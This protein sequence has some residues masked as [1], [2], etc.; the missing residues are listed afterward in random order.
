MAELVQSVQDML[1]EETWTRATIS[2][3]TQNNLKEFANIVEKAHSENCAD[4]IYDICQEHLSHSKDSIIA[5]YICGVLDL[6][7]GSLD[8]SSLVTLVDI[9]KNNH[10]E[11]I[12]TYLC[13]SILE[14]DPNNKFALRTLAEGYRA[15]G[16]EKYWDLYAHIVK[17]DFEEADLARLLAEHYE[18]AGDVDLTISYYKKAILR[19]I[20]NS[21]YNAIKEVWSKLIQYIPQEIDFFQLLRRKISKQMGDIRTTTLMQ[22]LYN[23]Y[24]DNAPSKK[25][26]WDVAITILKQNLEVEPKDIWARKEIADCF[27]GKYKEHSHLEEYIRTSN[28]T[29]SYRNVFEAIND[30][31]KHIAFDKGSYVFHRNWGVGRIRKLEG[32]TLT[33]N[34]GRIVGIKEMKLSMA[35]TALKP[36]AKDHIWVL[37]ATMQK[38]DL[39][40]SVKADKAETLKII[41]RSFDNNC[42]FK[43]IKAELVPSILTPGEWTSWNSAAKKI[44]ETDSNFGVNPNDISMYT[45]RDGNI[46]PEE[47]ISNEFKAQK[48]FFARADLLVKFF[49]S[50]DT[51]NSSE[52]FAEMYSYFTGYLKNISKVNEQVLASY[53]LVRS[54]SAIDKQF[55]FPVKETFAEIYNRIEDPKEIYLLLKDSKSTHFKDDFIRCIKLLPNWNEEYVKLFPIVLKEELLN[56]LIKEGH[57]E[58]VQKLVR[59]S[60]EAFKD[61]R[62]T[63]LF[64]FKECQDKDWFN[65]AGVS[66]E[67]QLIT[68]INIIELTFREIN[69]HVNSTENKKINKNAT[70]LLF[71]TDAIFNYMFANGED[72]VKKMYTLIDDIA[73]IDPSYKALARNKILEKYPDFKFRVSE[74]K[75]QQSVGLIVTAKK[76]AEKKAEVDEIQNVL[77]PKNAAEVADAKAKGD[78][79][80]NQE[81]KSAKEE[82]HFLNLKLTNLQN[83]LNRAVVFDPTTS[84]TAI[85]SFGTVATLK[86][87]QTGNEETYTILGPWESDPDNNVISYMA[88]FGDAILNKKVG[89]VLQFTINEHKY[90]YTVKN[91]SKA[92][93]I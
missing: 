63:V 46:S 40:K 39:I 76:L 70:D 20:N 22:E 27:R 89:D 75:K 77:I 3:Y 69:N 56:D 52:L 83:E 68:L 36:L 88:P 23:W 28:L 78:L 43:R 81:Y 67:K 13:E 85:I 44:L 50:D 66:Y 64:F 33:I 47:K 19:Y 61:F 37:K 26:Y 18:E 29:Q 38:E 45:V 15:E 14:D 4:E 55:A 48:Q 57:V 7:K 92:K 93:D 25:E 1:K 34:F 86:D 42:D 17:I 87:N 21:N 11:P 5:L 73:D 6:Q 62:E 60:F 79:K 53:L 59:T 35:V 31:E 72:A 2:N 54:I 71:K 10:K 58:D 30:F 9:F 51:D 80:E 82:Q 41:I 74:E 91:I 90:D 49:E 65:E 84:T 12:V 32:D 8:N 24:K 16:N